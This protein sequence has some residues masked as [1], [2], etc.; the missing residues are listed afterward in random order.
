MNESVY[1]N[2][3]QIFPYFNLTLG[4]IFSDSLGP[5]LFL[6]FFFFLTCKCLKTT[7]FLSCLCGA[8]LF[9][10]WG[11]NAGLDQVNILLLLVNQGKTS[12]SDPPLGASVSSPLEKRERV[13][14]WGGDTMI[15]HPSVTETS[16]WAVRASVFTRPA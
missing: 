12:A 15:S 11:K 14:C 8:R 7:S 10:S 13:S 16:F 1:A 9:S 3:M 4:N 2:D 5:R 6:I